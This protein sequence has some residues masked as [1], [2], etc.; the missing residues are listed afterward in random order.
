MTKKLRLVLIAVFAFIACACIFAGC[1]L[2][3][4]L[5][6]V[7][8]DLDK[9]GAVVAVTY[10]AN[11]GNFNDK[12]DKEEEEDKN[13]EDEEDE[14]SGSQ[15]GAN[16]NVP[17]NNNN[18]VRTIH[19]KAG[20]KAISID[21]MDN[22]SF[23]SGSITIAATD[24]G[25]YELENWYIAE[26]DGNGN[27]L[28]EDGTPY[29]F[30]YD[31]Q[32]FDSTKKIKH[33]GELFD[34]STA[35]EKGKHYYLVAE[36]RKIQTV[37]VILAGEASSIKTADKT[38]EKGDLLVDMKF[39]KSTGYIPK[40]SSPLTDTVTDAT[41]I[42]F[43]SDENCTEL[44]TGWNIK[45]EDHKDDDPEHPFTIYAK[46]IEGIW[47]VVKDASDV[48]T[49]FNGLTSSS[50]RYYI[51]S[52]NDS[53][54]NDIN[55]IDCSKITVT[56]IAG[57]SAGLACEIRGNGCEIIGLNVGRSITGGT[58]SQGASLFGA[59]K[60]TA[61][62]SDLILKDIT[63][64]YTVNPG[65]WVNPGIFFAFTSIHEDAKLN[66]NNVVISGTMEVT[67]IPST[68]NRATYVKNLSSYA[69]ESN[70]IIISSVHDAKNNWKFGG[71]ANDS[72]YTGGITV[73]SDD[74]CLTIE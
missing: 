33:T 51:F 7:L 53:D 45:Y 16:S 40:P 24:E 73:T 10:F 50:D 14:D 65:A 4:S 34:F 70:G 44:F 21:S 59:I 26:V 42:E 61:K 5:E 13:G 56:A 1:T 18:K 11:D 28:Y 68:S 35:L 12:T 17:K 71:Y 37:H 49:M 54:G 15:D 66:F 38:Y 27:P 57:S 6:D 30:S 32:Y 64:K 19:Y 22:S 36:W 29:E 39:E 9:K 74:S 63:Q 58:D 43:Y 47:T 67:I 31:T 52:V 55:D 48:R 46:Y 8:D 20:S 2:K 69:E 3:P 23:E 41:F 60:S 62:I 25:R 72:E